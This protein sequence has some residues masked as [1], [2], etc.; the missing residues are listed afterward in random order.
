MVHTISIPRRFPSALGR[1]PLALAAKRTFVVLVVSL[2]ASTVFA[3]DND[4][5]PK[6]SARTLQKKNAAFDANKNGRLNK[7][8]QGKARAAM[9]KRQKGSGNQGVD[10]REL[11][12]RFD[13]NGDGRLNEKERQAAMKVRGA[14]GS[15]RRS[16]GNTTD[17]AGGRGEFMKR[18]DKNGDGKL[19]ETERKAA[20][21]AFA[22]RR[23]TT[24]RAPSAKKSDTGRVSKKGLLKKFDNDGDGKLTGGERAAARNALEK[25]KPKSVKKK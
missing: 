3:A 18:F 22:D 17:R 25:R 6:R 1:A 19:D 14:N 4:S 2:V 16:G 12:K 21:S 20:R 5:K 23:S 11:L 15:D 24:D 7:S 9:A 13:K 10:R 8:E